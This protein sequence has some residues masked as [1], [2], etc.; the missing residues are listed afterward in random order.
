MKK[1]KLYLETS[2]WSHYYADDNEEQMENTKLLFDRIKEQRY[3]IFISLSVIKEINRTEHDKRIKLQELTE[4]YNPTTLEAFSEVYKLANKYIES[5]ILPS[6][7]Y[8]DAFHAAIASVYNLDILVSWN[9]KHLSNEISRNKI[10]MFNISN[11]YKPIL[12]FTPMEVISYE[13]K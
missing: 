2:I 7:S 9:C 11:G 3:D 4:T 8:E 6:N 13:G 10:N 1:L 5:R 12:I